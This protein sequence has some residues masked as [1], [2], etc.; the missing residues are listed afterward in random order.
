MEQELKKI[1]EDQQQ[2]IDEIYISVEKT[3]KY[4]FWTMIAT[5]V[6]FVL[7]L[8]LMA[9]TLPALISTY[10]STLGDLGF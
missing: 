8:I 4:L 9:I 7:P 2:K 10:T 1:I 5:L 3:R 6:F